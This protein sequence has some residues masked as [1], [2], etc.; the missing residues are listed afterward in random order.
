MAVTTPTPDA[1]TPQPSGATSAVPTG[2]I[3]PEYPRAAIR[4]GQEG[5]VIV[6]ADVRADGTV[7]AA[8]VQK[9]SGHARLDRAARQ[10][11]LQARFT[12]ARRNG[13]PVPAS[14]TV[15]VRFALR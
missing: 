2:P 10:A 15:P 14:V 12:P 11:V 9:S 6:A 7:A 4:R 8:R 1:A 13:R 5:L 3:V